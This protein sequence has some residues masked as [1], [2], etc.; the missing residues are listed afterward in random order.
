MMI[1]FKDVSLKEKGKCMCEVLKMLS[2]CT[3]LRMECYEV[4]LDEKDTKSSKESCSK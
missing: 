1:D 4:V 3:W 2:A